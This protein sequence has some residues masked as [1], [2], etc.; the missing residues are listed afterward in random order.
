[1]TFRKLLDRNRMS[2]WGEVR[3]HIV[4]I[5]TSRSFM[6]NSYQACKHR[7]H[8]EWQW[9]LS[10]VHSIM[11]EKSAQPGE[12]GVCTPVVP[13]FTLSTITY[14]VY[15]S[16]RSSGDGISTPPISTLPLYVLCAR[17]PRNFNEKLC[18]MF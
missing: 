9:P 12:D 1:M 10:G 8:T 3:V 4:Q 7:V 5:D 17:E 2:R 16:V 14:K 18:Q 15:C 11:M 6:L 13:P